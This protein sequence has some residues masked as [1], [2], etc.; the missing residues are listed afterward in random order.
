MELPARAEGVQGTGNR[1]DWWHRRWSAMTQR[2]REA[3]S[4][5]RDFFFT[6]RESVS[7]ENAG[8]KLRDDLRDELVVPEGV[9]VKRSGTIAY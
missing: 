5:G 6:I 8:V 2:N 7:P 9:S 3:G 1:C 4:G